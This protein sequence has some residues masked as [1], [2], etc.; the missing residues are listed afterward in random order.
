M[1]GHPREMLGY[2]YAEIASY[3]HD[4]LVQHSLLMPLGCNKNARK[5]K[6]LLW[7]TQHATL[8]YLCL[9]YSRSFAVS[10]RLFS[11]QFKRYF[12]EHTMYSRKPSRIAI[13][14]DSAAYNMTCGIEISSNWKSESILDCL[15][16]CLLSAGWTNYAKKNGQ[17][18]RREK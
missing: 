15:L 4:Q 2:Y 8:T 13:T 6:T 3:Q 16:A 1:L 7:E 5:L 12:F 18:K 17:A 14:N 9:K 10:S 11:N